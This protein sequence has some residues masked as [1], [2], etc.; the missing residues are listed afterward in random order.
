MICPKCGRSLFIEHED[1]MQ[2]RNCWRIVYLDK[3]NAPIKYQMVFIPHGMNVQ[4]RL[5][6]EYTRR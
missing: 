2:C 4:K 3:H 6:P 1:G 5:E